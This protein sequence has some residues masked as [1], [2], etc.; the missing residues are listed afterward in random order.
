VGYISFTDL[1]GH[2]N[3]SRV[4]ILLSETYRE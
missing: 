3:K 4:Q 2:K 1:V